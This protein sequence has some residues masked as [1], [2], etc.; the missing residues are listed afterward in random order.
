MRTYQSSSDSELL[1]K[2]LRAYRGNSCLEIGIGY[3]SNLAVLEGK[4][5]TVVGTDLFLTEGFRAKQGPGVEV[6]VA[7][8][9][10]CFRDASF[11][12]VVMNPPYLPSEKTVDLAV[13][14]GKRGFEVPKKFLEEGLRVI[15]QFGAILILLS[16]ET[17]LEDFQEFCKAKGLGI[18]PV[19]STGAFFE[20]L[21]VF[22]LSK[23]G[24]ELMEA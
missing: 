21:T 4:F 24:L 5:S 20:T 2:A 17:S 15:K 13:D 9:A 22:E 16:S 11:D 14:G 19:L 18:K 3:G 8:R 23:K 6:F 10:T 12:L 7:D 1:R